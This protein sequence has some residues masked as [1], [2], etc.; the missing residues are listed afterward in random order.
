MLC[1]TAPGMTVLT[2]YMIFITG[3]SFSTWASNAA[4]AIQQLILLALCIYFEYIA[5]CFKGKD[6][7]GESKPLLDNAASTGDEANGEDIPV[8]D[9]SDL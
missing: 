1:I 3:Q 6:T 8:A 4:S 5:K 7:K 9:V 2:L